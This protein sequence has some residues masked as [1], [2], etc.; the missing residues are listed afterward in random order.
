DDL[1]DAGEVAELLGLASSNVVNVYRGRYPDFPVPVIERRGFR[2]WLRADVE[3]WARN[4]GRVQQTTV[5][6]PRRSGVAN[7][8][9]D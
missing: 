5:T 7:R 8:K 1:L 4:T 3:S 2:L 9:A 6:A